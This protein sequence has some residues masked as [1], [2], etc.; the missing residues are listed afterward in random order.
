VAGHIALGHVAD[1]LEDD[2]AFAQADVAIPDRVLRIDQ[3][4]EQAVAVPIDLGE[5]GAPAASAGAA[6]EA[7]RAEIFSLA[8]GMLAQVGICLFE[9]RGR[10]RAAR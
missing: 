5:L 10:G 7:E 2:L 8:K 4:I 9:R 1:L 6:V 3:E